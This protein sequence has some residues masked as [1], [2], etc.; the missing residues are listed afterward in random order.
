[1]NLLRDVPTSRG[2]PSEVSSG[3]GATPRG[4]ARRS[5]RSRSR[6][7]RDALL[8]DPLFGPRPSLGEAALDVVRDVVV[9]R[10][11]CIVRG[12]PRRCMRTSSTPAR[13]RPRRCAARREG[14]DVVDHLRAG[15]E[16]RVGHRQLS[17]CRSRPRRGRGET[18]DHR[19]DAGRVPPS[20]LTAAAPGRVDSPPTSRTPAPAAARLSPVSIARPRSRNSPPSEKE[21]GVTL[22]TPMSAP[23]RL[24]ALRE[25]RSSALYSEAEAKAADPAFTRTSNEHATAD[26]T[27]K[28][29][30]KPIPTGG[31]RHRSGAPDRPRL[32]LGH[33]RVAASR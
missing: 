10:V 18:L 6:D 14:R 26:P 31:A 2:R 24:D 11:V 8:G 27:S 15:V 21:S 20:P 1:M 5:C 17:R 16:R 29:R 32:L 25:V 28:P 22:T 33:L 3:G 23:A 7:R 19:A 9:A 4:C 13:R 30:R 12:V